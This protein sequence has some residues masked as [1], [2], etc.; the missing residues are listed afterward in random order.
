MKDKSY[1]MNTCMEKKC[2]G[3]TTRERFLELANEEIIMHA[4]A[5][6]NE[7]KCVCTHRMAFSSPNALQGHAFV[8]LRE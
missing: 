2:S 6:L 8:V 5:C 7:S 1:R 3:R 4:S